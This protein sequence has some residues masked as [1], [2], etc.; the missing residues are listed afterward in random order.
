MGSPSD[1]PTMG[2]LGYLGLVALLS[3]GIQ[4]ASLPYQDGYQLHL[5]QNGVIIDL[6]MKDLNPLVGGKAHVE[7]PISDIWRMLEL[8]AQLLRPIISSLEKTTLPVWK[9]LEVEAPFLK[10]IL[11]AMEKNT[12]GRIYDVMT[13][14]ADITYNAE[15][16]LKGFFNVAVDYTLVHKDGTEE[17]ATLLIQ[18][19]N[20][21]GQSV[22]YVE[23]IPKNNVVMPEKKIFFPLE[24]IIT[25]N[26]PSAHTLSIKGD[27]GKMFINIANDMNEV[28]VRG[29]MELLGQQYKH[30][31]IL[32][33]REKYFTITFQEPSK[34]LYDIV[35]KFNMLNGFPR[36]DITGNIPT[37]QYFKAGDFKTEVIVNSWLDYELKHTFHGVEI[38]RLTFQML[39]G[40]PR[41]EIT[42]KIPTFQY[43]TAGVFKSQLIVKSL[44]N[45]EIKH[46]FKG[47]ELLN[48]KIAI[49]NGKMEMIVKYGQTHKTHIVLEYAYL[50]WIKILLPT[51]NTWLSKDLGVEMHYQ[52]TNEAKLL[53]GGNILI[54]AKHDNIPVM[55]MGG[56]Y[57]LTLDST[58]YEILLNDFC[59]SLLNKEF[60]I[61]EGITF[62][63]LNFSGKILLNRLS[64]NGLIPKMALEA[65]IHM[66]EQK[67]FHYLLTTIET[68]CK[69]HIF[70]PYLFQNLLRMTQGHI[71]ITHEHVVLENKQIISTLCNLTTK[72]IITTV[73]PTMMSLELFDGEV[74]L[75]KYVT[76]LTKVDVGRNSMLLE[77][78]KV[79]QF[80]AYQ[81]WFLPTALGFKQLKTKFHIEVVDKAEGKMNINVAVIK[82]T[83]EIINA[84]V[85]NVEVPYMM[86]VKAPLLPLEMKV[87]YELSP[88]VWNIKINNRS[89]LEVRPTITNEV[90][91]VL[92]G[93]PLFRVALL[94]KEVRITTI[95]KDLP[96]ITTA[97]TLK[98]FSLFQNTLGIEVM[99]GKISHKTLLGWNINMLRK[100]FVDVKVIGS[101]TE[102]LGDYELLHH[103]N[104]N[105]V[106]LKNIDF[107]WTGKVM[108]TALKVLKTPLVTEGKLLFKDF[109]VD[110]KMVEKLMNVPYTLIFKSHPLTAAF[111]PFFQYP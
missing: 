28:S 103:L 36:I 31:T 102:L 88:K 59:V 50:R 84:V 5:N 17:K 52:P 72:K 79:V 62:S 82:D 33:I 22:T 23:I 41:M 42:G 9:L 30:S 95:M 80:N 39:N 92:T 58:E 11:I 109:V 94:A 86:V 100:A 26:W 19:K 47:M 101:G 104:W 15:E 48:L 93:V 10:P 27:F 70:F 83:T 43:F 75:V 45:Y 29:V 99:V 71:E 81:P 66:D 57:G 35:I 21:S 61:F 51:T 98:T 78:N 76:E 6:E 34:D 14:K 25:C 67:V 44:Y 4:G 38:L 32:S 87:D 55:K 90:E 2:C 49:K 40:F 85:N 8:D 111:L 63:D 91:V 20:Q 108:C 56:Y 73:T 46:I 7:L 106:S 105:I 107:E 69:L 65:K 16:I 53:E 13:L 77:G 96:E 64:M 18:E 68:P 37:F 24:M 110:M 97:V 60:K 12:L 74:S 3:C 89:I 1:S 54:V